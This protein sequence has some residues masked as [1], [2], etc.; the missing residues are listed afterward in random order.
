M[1]PRIQALAL[2]FGALVIA[3]APALAANQ[4]VTATPSN[5]FTPREVTINPGETVTWKNDGGSHNV[6]FD[7]GSF[8]QPANGDTSAWTVQRTFSS[9]GTFRYYCEDHG[10]AGGVGMAG[11]VTVAAPGGQPGGP[12]PAPTLKAVSV[13]LRVSDSRP[14]RG[15]VVRFRGSVRP[16]RDGALVYIERRTRRGRYRRVAR[17]RLRDAGASR[18]RFSRRIRLRRGGVFRARVPGDAG[19]RTGRSRARRIRVG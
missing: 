7:D 13:S 2:A 1:P 4:T 8:E 3:A 5:D 17:A 18:S 10:A 14:R 12:P 6:K 11:T 19:H 16:A 15:Q 9:P